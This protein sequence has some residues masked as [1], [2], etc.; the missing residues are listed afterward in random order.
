MGTKGRSAPRIVCCA[1]PILRTAGKVLVVTSRKRP[2][3]WV[4]PKGGWEQ[5]DGQLEAAASREAL[6]EGPT[7]CSS[8][9]LLTS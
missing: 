5:S 3:N 1:I 8:L 2:N 9:R 7:I 6:E 4:L